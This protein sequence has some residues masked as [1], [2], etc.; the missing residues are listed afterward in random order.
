MPFTTFESFVEWCKEVPQFTIE[1]VDFEE[2]TITI[3][4][5]Y[6]TSQGALVDLM[7]A[8]H[9]SGFHFGPWIA[10]RKNGSL[11]IITG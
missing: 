2:E 1:E 9:D 10:D 3:V 7:V 5:I 4:D 8:A 11:M 6:G